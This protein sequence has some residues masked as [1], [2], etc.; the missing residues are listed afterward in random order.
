MERSPALKGLLQEIED[1]RIYQQFLHSLQAYGIG[2]ICDFHAHISSG[3]GDFLPTA[4][5]G[6]VAELP[7]HPF[8]LE[9]VY[10]FYEALFRS[11]GLEA[12]AVVFDTP[13]PAYDIRKKNLNLLENLRQ[14][15]PV[16]AAKLMPFAIVTP[17]MQAAELEE[18]LKLGARGFKTTPRVSRTYHERRKIPDVSLAEMLSPASLKLAESHRIPF[19]IH[20]PQL[21][22]SA[23][24][25]PSLKE[26]LERVLLTY[27]DL[28]LVLAHLGLCQTP[29]KLA[30]LLGW[31]EE[32]NFG[33][34]IWLDVSAITLPEA[35]ELVLLSPAQLLFGTDMDFC[36]TERGR[37]ILIKHEATQRAVLVSQSLG[38]RFKGLAQEQGLELNA[39]L[40]LF[41]LEGLMEA[42]ARL[43]RK[44]MDK[45]ELKQRLKALFYQNAEQILQ[46]RLEGCSRGA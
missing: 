21:M 43:R 39:P 23:E 17:Q 1:S 24:L 19:L 38:K 20:L 12:L 5:P 40:F 35:F 32:K 45:E 15:Q 28:R 25:D 41:Q 34:R 6:E 10:E 14:L 36:L 2:Q 42:L 22:G 16:K 8:S 33:R 37:Y 11:R 46:N 26:G 18:Y 13:L 4:S 27:P 7:S 9:D 30:D 3:R 31:M 29:S 44:G